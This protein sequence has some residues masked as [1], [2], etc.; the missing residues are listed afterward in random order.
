[1]RQIIELEDNDDI[2]SIRSRIDFALPKLTQQAV[3]AAD[4]PERARLLVVVPRK[5]KT[6]HSL[7]NM[8]LLARTVKS[9][10]VE[11][12]IVSPQPIVR[13]Y[14]KE[15]GVKAFGSMWQAKLAGWAKKETPVAK[16]QETLPPVVSTVAEAPVAEPE[17]AVKK[18]RKSTPPKRKRV[19]KKK[20]EVVSGSG[21]PGVLRLI[22]KQLAVL[23]LI[24]MLAV[25]LVAGVIALLPEATVTITPVAQPVEASLV[26]KAAPNV[27]AVD[28][29]ALT[30]P[31]RLNQVELKL[32]G[33]IE[34]VETELLPTGQAQGN[35][36]F[37]NRT[38]DEQTIPISTTL[39]TSAGN[40]VEF[41]TVQTATIPAG[42]GATST[43]TL[44][45]A[46]APGPPGNVAAGQI[47]RF[48]DPGFGR[49]ARVIN[50]QPTSGGTL[51]PARIVVQDDKDR[52]QAH[53]RQKV[54]Q[55]G[56]RQLQDALGEQEFIPPES[57]QVIVLDVK[58]QELSGDFSDT[59][60]GEMQAV[61]RATVIG[62]YNANRLSLAALESQVPAGYRLDLEGLNFG[63]GE[64]LDITDNVVTFRIFAEGQAIPVI[65]QHRVAQDITWMS[66]GEAQSLLD[67][68][69]QLATVPG[70]E[71]KPDWLAQTVGRLPLIS[72]R[73]N[74]VVKEAITLVASE[75]S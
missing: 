45:I 7:V 42:S 5:N 48:S 11:M 46:T 65:D 39:S 69:Y 37:I 2:T 68:Q 40:P 73:I 56:L 47:N 30:F 51:E 12:A 70:V 20:F 67:E 60:G 22:F 35:V 17:K 19:Q 15:A 26:V 66:I 75:G 52:L 34:T 58:Y 31:A 44:V 55:E 8:K 43:P 62:G 3:Q 24:F 18:K 38:D 28:F 53:L 32:F 64:V 33:Q 9:R 14:A 72:F 50:E 57:V 10:A 61:V 74:V 25:A 29:Q 4:K 41:I 59:L 36:V 71:L 1:M 6:L 54:Q 23:T 49:L 13:D 21:K 16:P 63:A 27:N